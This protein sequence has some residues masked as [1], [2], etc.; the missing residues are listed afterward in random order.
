MQSYK[1]CGSLLV[2]RG[3]PHQVK[4][5]MNVHSLRWKIFEVSNQG[6]HGSSQGWICISGVAREYYRPK[7]IYDIAASTWTPICID[8]NTSKS[9]FY[10]SFNHYARILVDIDLSGQLHD[11]MLVEKTGYSFYWTLILKNSIVLVMLAK[12]LSIR[13][14]I[15][16]KP[17][18]KE[19]MRRIKMLKLVKRV[20]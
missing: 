12:M 14:M 11:K 17:R 7:L 2:S 18:F 9:N 8:N 5:F 19:I 13:S 16:I 1:V 10:R 20:P 6:T 15:E 3:L 4:I